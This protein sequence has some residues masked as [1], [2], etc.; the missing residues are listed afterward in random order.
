MDSI[1]R[2]IIAL[3]QNNGRLSITEIAESVGLSLSPCHRRIKK[4]EDDRIITGYKAQIDPEKAGLGF[5][6]LVF[7][8][9]KGSD[10]HTV[11]SFED[12]VKNMDQVVLA[13]RLFGE[14]DYL[15]QVVTKNLQD[16]QELY[17]QSLSKITS[18]QRLTSTIVMKTVVQNRPIPVDI[19]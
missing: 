4:L 14:P 9:L 12:A 3:L 15:L 18:V 7:V 19:N 16:Y 10:N 5:S 13:Q 6:A 8:T 2:K 11:E 17:D 1:D